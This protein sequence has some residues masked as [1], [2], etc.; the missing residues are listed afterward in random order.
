MWSST[1]PVGFH[2]K[3]MALETATG[4]HLYTVTVTHPTD[5]K[6]DLDPTKRTVVGMLPHDLTLP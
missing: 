1:P 2:V 5:G 4:D 3:E 6:T